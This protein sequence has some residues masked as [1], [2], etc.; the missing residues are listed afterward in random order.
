MRLGCK[1]GFQTFE[2]ESLKQRFGLRR[3]RMAR[4]DDLVQD[5]LAQKK[6]AVVGISDKRETGCNEA[7]KRFKKN[8]YKVYAV[9]PRMSTYDSQPC[10]A[11]LESIPEKVD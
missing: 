11:D 5:F 8:G 1:A 7:Y 3:K 6:I 4:I 2:S 9:N 10:Y